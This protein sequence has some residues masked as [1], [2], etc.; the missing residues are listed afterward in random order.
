V[1]DDV[2]AILEQWHRE[3]P[4]LPTEAMGIFGR[5][6]RISAT[7][8]AAM[9]ETYREFGISR[10]EFDV[11]ATLRRSGQPYLTP[12]SLAASMMMTTG[13]MTGRLDR[14]ESAGLLTRAQ[15]PNDRRGL[16]VSLTTAGRT[17]VDEAVLA[18]VTTQ[19]RLLAPLSARQRADLTRLLSAL[20]SA[21]APPRP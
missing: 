20:M 14:L 4:D 21:T 6:F 19:E 11:L 1:T 5:V 9:A 10:T 16:R 2:D 17:L 3:R 18:G 12:G 13:G 7:V 15:D 8:G